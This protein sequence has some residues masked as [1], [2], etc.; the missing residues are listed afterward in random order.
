MDLFIGGG[1]LSV[2]FL[3]MLH[4][5]VNQLVFQRWIR[6]LKQFKVVGTEQD[7]SYAI[8]RYFQNEDHLSQGFF[9]PISCI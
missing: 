1:L 7:C 9:L 8:D 6:E 4:C 2:V 3:S 5:T